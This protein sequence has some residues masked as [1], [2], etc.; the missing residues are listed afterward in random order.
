MAGQ[1]ETAAP[2]R[3]VIL[4]GASNVARGFSTIVATARELW[5]EP[6]DIVAALGHGRSFGQSNNVLGRTLP[7]I[8]PCGLWQALEQRPRL[9]A[10]AVVTDIGNDLLYGVPAAR[11]LQ[12]VGEVTLRLE[13][14]CQRVVVTQ[15]PLDSIRQMRRERFLLMRSI[16][17]PRSRLGYDQALL[18]AE[19]LGAGLRE[20]VEQRGGT[21]L[22]PAAEWYGWDPIHIRRTLFADAWRSVLANCVGAPAQSATR[23]PR[24]AWHVWWRLHTL[25]PEQRRM[26]GIEQTRTQPA[27]YFADGTRI[28]LY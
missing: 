14:T 26:F 27:H 3:R 4:L 15:L 23:A 9:P 17:F 13:T 22:E 18:A 21:L 1:A 11:V 25:R 16:F 6:L 28:S 2:A 24:I 8:L 7:G 5:D 19:E 10:V 20:L 12:W